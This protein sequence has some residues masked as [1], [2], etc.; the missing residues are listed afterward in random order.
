M[1]GADSA[2]SGL[3]RTRRGRAAAAAATIGKSLIIALISFV[4][5]LLALV[6]AAFA[7][8]QAVLLVGAALVTLWAANAAGQ[9]LL[10]LAPSPGR[11]PVAGIVNILITTLIFFSAFLL[12]AGEGPPA[13]AGP[14]SQWLLA[15]GSRIAYR[16]FLPDKILHHEPIIFLHGGPGVSDLEGDAAFF[17]RL[18]DDG[19][20]VYVYDQA[21]AGYSSRLED[22]RGYGM[23]RAVADLEEIR[24]KIG[25]DRI[26]LIGH[27]YGA[28]L[29]SMYIARFGEHVARFI[30]SSPGALVGGLAGGGDL[31]LRL[32]PSDRRRLYSLVLQPRPFLVY[33]LLQIN[34]KA[35]HS[36]AGDAEMDA[37][38]RAVYAATEPA[39][40]CGA[41]RAEEGGAYPGFYANQ[42]PQSARYEGPADYRA[43]LGRFTIPTL[44]IK[45]SCDYLRWDS[46]LEYL[47][48]FSKGPSR[49][50]YLRRAGHNA[51]Q[52]EP[53][54]FMANVRAFLRDLPPPDEYRGRKAPEDYEMSNYK[55][56]RNA[57]P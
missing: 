30:A 7:V 55:E 16:W 57:S 14:P 52:D 50:V 36:L 15:T 3:A 37:R 21:G 35:A 8:D 11:V 17:G 46:A 40:H 9:S 53:E 27:S 24:E 5:G 41:S 28:A 18:R 26:I 39:L 51:Y 13:A 49:L 19:Y 23:S 1:A 54:G 33:V 2:A 32:S 22:P 44:V 25:A 20:T 10:G 48:A 43:D 29:G 42:Y 38:F 47:D 45:G 34:P 31:Q 12:P 6:G 56:F 4:L